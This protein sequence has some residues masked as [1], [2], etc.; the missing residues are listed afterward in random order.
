MDD[1]AEQPYNT[2]VFDLGGVL[3]DWNPV[4]LYRKLL[5]TEDEVRHF[6]DTVCTLHWN[7]EQDAGRSLREGTEELVG[8][9]P[10]QEDLIR[11]YYG[12]WEEMLGGPINGTVEILKH[13]KENTPLRLYALTN[14]SAE[15]FPVALER[16]EFLHWFQGIL[17]SGAE[18]TRKPF[19]DICRILTDR[20][21]ID[22]AKAIYIDDNPRN[23]PPAAGRA[24]KPSISNRPDNSGWN[25]NNSA[26][27]TTGRRPKKDP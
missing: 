13:L 9:F 6:L 16:Y 11:A 17:V 18:K 15:T 14:W 3:V 1:A 19:P 20:F 10:E 8:R 22:P 2:L 21:R 4:Y 5:N 23:L 7:E 12:R 24:C 25:W 26:C 27:L